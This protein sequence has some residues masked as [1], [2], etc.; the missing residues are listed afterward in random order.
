M[1][2]DVFG[3]K[4]EENPSVQDALY[5]VMTTDKY[6]IKNE[7]NEKDVPL[8]EDYY[9]NKK[10]LPKIETK[11]TYINNSTHISKKMIP[12]GFN[13][14]T[15]IHLEKKLVKI[16]ENERL[17]SKGRGR[18]F[19]TKAQKEI[20]DKFRNYSLEKENQSMN[21]EENPNNSMILNNNDSFNIDKDKILKDKNSNQKEE[22]DKQSN[23]FFI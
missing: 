20:L 11:V 21:W 10:D 16:G 13:E 23:S 12:S 9:K 5:E 2:E 22:N 14:R 3:K 15:N 19:R 6:Y 1:T 7:K 4:K 8:A 18:K 17:N